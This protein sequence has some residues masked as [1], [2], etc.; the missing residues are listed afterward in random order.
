MKNLFSEFRDISFKEWKNKA[1]YDL[2]GKEFNESL[3]WH[4]LEGINVPPYFSPDQKIKSINHNRLPKGKTSIAKY[5]ILRNDTRSIN[6]FKSF[7]KEEFDTIKL[8]IPKNFDLSQITSLQGLL[9][10]NIQFEFELFTENYIVN[11]VELANKIESD[12]KIY[13]NLDFIGRLPI[14]GNWI[15]SEKQ[16]FDLLLKVSKLNDNIIPYSINSTFYQNSGANILQQIAYSLAT[17]VEYAEIIGSDFFAKVQYNF[18]IGSNFFFEIAKLSTFDYLIDLIKQKYNVNSRNNICCESSFRNKT[19]YDAH[20]NIL[21]STTEAMSAMIAN[22]DTFISSSF[23]STYNNA[24]NFSSRIG[25]NQLLIL[26]EEAHIEKVENIDEGSYY[27]DFIKHE[28]AEKSLE[29]F[30]LIENGGGILK[31]L[32]EGIIQR[33]VNDSSKKEQ[34]Q[35]D[36]NPNSRISSEEN[37]DASIRKYPFLKFKNRKTTFRLIYPR[38][39]SEEIEKKRL[40]KEKHNS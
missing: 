4:G 25:Y 20:S 16:D 40:N 10:K 24:N 14:E 26:S 15:E 7:V 33:K 8:F 32:K 28:L 39:L 38:R 36:R 17:A 27:V 5:F 1:N 11:I 31:Q 30:K 3:N 9:N 13:L 29:I 6:I 18:A 37:M 2:N 19:I 35:F 12:C 23:D 21:R 22:T 34:K